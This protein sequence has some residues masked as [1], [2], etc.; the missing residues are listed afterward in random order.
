MN[1]LSLF[2]IYDMIQQF[3]KK[4]DKNIDDLHKF[5]RKLYN[6]FGFSLVQDILTILNNTIDD[7]K[8]KQETS[9]A[10]NKRFAK[11]NLKLENEIK[12]L[13]ETINLLNKTVQ[14]LQP[15]LTGPVGTAYFVITKKI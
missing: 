4:N 10:K 13:K 14:G 9:H 2:E 5:T 7:M 12:Q 1:I 8:Y 6:A 15:K 11:A 3:E